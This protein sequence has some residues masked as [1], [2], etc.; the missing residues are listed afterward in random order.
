MKRSCATKLQ[1]IRNETAMNLQRNCDEGP[2][3]A[4]FPNCGQR[5]SLFFIFAGGDCQLT[6]RG[7]KSPARLG[8]ESSGQGQS[9]VA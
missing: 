5:G 7:Q 1:R 3:L 2:L 6:S 4:F 9:E 8:E